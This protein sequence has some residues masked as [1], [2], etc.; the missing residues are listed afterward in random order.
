M[1]GKG[2][3][4]VVLLVGMTATVLGSEVYAASARRVAVTALPAHY[5]FT[6][7]VQLTNTG[8][9]DA[10]N[11]TADVVLKAPKTAYA[12]VTVVGSSMSP[13]S[14]HRDASGNV[15][16]VFRFGE[17]APGQTVTLALDYQATSSD[18]SY[19]LPYTYPHYNTASQIYRRYTDPARESKVIET[20][21]P[22]IKALD[23]SIT[24]GMQ[25]PY[26]R[27]QALFN[28]VSTHIHYNTNLKATG[29]ALATL[30]ER[31][32]VC[33]D[34]ADLYVSMLRTDHIPARVVDGYVTNNGNGQEGLHQWVE[35]YLPQTGWVAA[36]P[37]WGVGYFAELQDNWHIPLYDGLGPDVSVNWQYGGNAQNTDI[38]VRDSYHFQSDGARQ[39]SRHR[40]LPLGGET[41]SV[42]DHG[43]S[44]SPVRGILSLWHEVQAALANYL[45]RV[46]ILWHSL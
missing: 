26:R 18:V 45:L 10:F 41:P 16:G 15:V 44:H 8:R 42:V 4:G 30:Q 34:I 19:H 11:V 43:A 9:Q 20:N 21:A 46:K 24:G 37:T 5:T 12:H 3:A 22:A 6:K 35:F 13:A 28:W 2:A 40:V 1:R 39:G 27:A 14:V 25:N 31:R 33:S 36:D 23:Q 17:L 29:S 7:T 38:R 32:G